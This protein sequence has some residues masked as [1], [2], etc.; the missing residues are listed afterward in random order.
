MPFCE[1]GECGIDEGVGLLFIGVEKVNGVGQVGGWT[2][3]DKFLVGAWIEV[4]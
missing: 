3:T 2:K 4:S 1:G